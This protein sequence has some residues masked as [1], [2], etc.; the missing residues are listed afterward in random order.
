MSTEPNTLLYRG[1]LKSCNYHCSYCPFSKHPCSRRELE[2]DRAQWEDF[3][4]RLIKTASA[5]NIRAV[6]LAPYGEALLYPWYWEGLAALS[7]SPD[8]DCVGAQS[9]F[10]FP[11]KDSLRQ[12]CQAGGVLQ[13]LRIWATFH[14]EMITPEAFAAKCKEGAGFGLTLCT[15]A[16]GVPENLAVIQRLRAL[17]PEEI[18]L[19]VNQMDGQKSPYTEETIAAFSEID[20][21]FYRDLYRME[22]DP[23]QCLGR[24]F[25]EGDGK[26]Y[27]CNINRIPIDNWRCWPGRGEEEG[28]KASAP[29]MSVPKCTRRVCSCYLAYGGRS[30]WMNQVLFGPYPIFRI[31]RRPKAVFLDIDGTLFSR[32]HGILP[33]IRK[34]LQVLA[35]REQARLFFA[36]SLPYETAIKRCKGI[37]HLFSGGVFA[38][39]GHIRVELLSPS[40]EVKEMAEGCVWERFY[41][42]PRAILPVLQEQQKQLHFRI[43]TYESRREGGE[44]YKVSLLR[45]RHK[46]WKEL[47]AEA[48]FQLLMQALLQPSAPLRYFLEGHCMELVAREADKARGALWICRQLSIPPEQG[49]AAGDGAEDVRLMELFRR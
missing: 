17:L 24:L 7:Q 3:Y 28:E 25:A 41:P 5:R 13:K 37:R 43:L 34:G 35:E 2:Q 32:E 15:G 46:P 38:G 9:N 8:L 14:P 47:E 45:P 12:F 10:S 36:T 19:W 11:L 49:A 29:P 48:L 30:H 42:I 33:E 22:A 44:L 23:S 20:P 39:G 16:V 4:P 26:L 1:T 21:Y 27:P 18:Y 6:M 31:P 40:T